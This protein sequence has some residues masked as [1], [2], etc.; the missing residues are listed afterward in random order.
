MNLPVDN[1][2]CKISNDCIKL[3]LRLIPLFPNFVVVVVVFLLF[4]V[5]ICQSPFQD[6]KIQ[7]TV[8][9]T[10]LVLCGALWKPFITLRNR[11]RRPCYSLKAAKQAF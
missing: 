8:L 7:N 4:F 9:E 6:A 5:Y 10:V 3:A 2:P 1:A 11:G